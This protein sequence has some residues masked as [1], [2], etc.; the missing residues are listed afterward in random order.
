VPLGGHEEPSGPPLD[1][2]KYRRLSI[3]FSG[4]FFLILPFKFVDN[5]SIIRIWT[6]WS[7][8][9]WQLAW[10]VDGYR[11]SS[12]QWYLVSV[13]NMPRSSSSSNSRRSKWSVICEFQIHSFFCHNLNW[14]FLWNSNEFFDRSRLG[15]ICIDSLAPQHFWSVTY[16]V[17]ELH[18][19]HQTLPPLQFAKKLQYK[20]VII[21]HCCHSITWNLVSTICK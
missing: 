11:Y 18:L 12:S 19:P 1:E 20:H 10:C 8:S 15:T 6:T 17:Q 5:P 9:K 14:I 21:S 4:L 3:Q 7:I 2:A 13:I 16:C